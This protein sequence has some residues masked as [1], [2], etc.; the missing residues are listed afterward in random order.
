MTAPPG[1]YWA[2]Q[3][4]SV[5]ESWCFRH[6]HF[7]FEACVGPYGQGIVWSRSQLVALV[8]VAPSAEAPSVS[9]GRS[10]QPAE[11]AEPAASPSSVTGESSGPSGPS[12]PL[13]PSGTGESS[14]RSGP[15]GS[16]GLS[17][18]SGAS[19]VEGS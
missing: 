16:S 18:S 15:S 12:E 8:S 4:Q 2:N 17:G 14:G 3:A 13:A 5:C 7:R 11:P 1:S 6:R 10:A 9:L 19:L